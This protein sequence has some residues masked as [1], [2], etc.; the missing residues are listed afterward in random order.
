MTKVMAVREI[1]MTIEMREIKMK[2]REFMMT[3]TAIKFIMTI[4]MT[5]KLMI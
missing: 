5:I 3:M 4:P 2:M 1:I